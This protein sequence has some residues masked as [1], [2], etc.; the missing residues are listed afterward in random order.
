[1]TK[2]DVKWVGMINYHQPF[3]KEGCD[4]CRHRQR[5]QNA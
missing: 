4:D 5:N 2:I 1:M 3:T